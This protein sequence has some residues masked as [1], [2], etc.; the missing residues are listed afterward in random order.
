MNNDELPISIIIH[1]RSLC[2]IIN[3][4]DDGLSTIS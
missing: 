4:V 1:Q 3:T 2:V